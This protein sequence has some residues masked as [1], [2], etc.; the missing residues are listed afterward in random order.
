MKPTNTIGS[1]PQ[2]R[3][4]TDEQQMIVASGA[5]TLKVVAGAGCGKSSTLYAYATARRGVRGLYMAFS[6]ALEIEAKP[7]LLSLGVNTI[8]KT[9]HSLAWPMF[10]SK[11]KAAGKLATG[12]SGAVTTHALGL[13]NRGVG[14]AVNATLVNYMSSV[15]MEISD[16]HLPDADEFPAVK[17]YPGHVVECARK[18]WAKMTNIADPTKCTHDVYLK[19]W[20]MTKPILDYPFIMLDECQDS[21]PLIVDLVN[22]QTHATRVYVGDPHQAI[23]A[24][25]GAIDLMGTLNSEE[26]LR[27]TNSWRFGANIG[28]LASTFLKHW[29]NEATP[30]RGAGQPGKMTATDTRAYLT[31][32]VARLIENAVILQEE[33]GRKLY[34]VGPEGL[35]GYRTQPIMEAYEMFAGT[36]NASARTDPTLRLMESWEDFAE[37]AEAGN[38]GEL[39]PVFKLIDKHRNEIPGMLR[40]LDQKQVKAATL[41]EAQKAGATA[42]LTTAHR[43][44]GLEFPV[45]I[46]DRDFPSLKDRKTEKWLNPSDVAADELNLMYVA[47]TRAMKGVKLPTELEEWFRTRPETARLMPPAPPSKEGESSKVTTFRRPEQAER[48]TAY[49]PAA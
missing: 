26:T 17:A 47:L 46:I 7:K 27:L 13:K 42:A 15:D 41:E 36:G 21:N 12:L 24:F 20:C 32:T 10:G 19:Q 45:V 43:S 40:R 9:Q 5:K 14:S 11:L 22:R 1:L 33:K 16:R 28:T 29:K 18:F 34:W 6:K 48:D 31:R 35:A 2:F 3:N 37:Y 4:L 25:R 39:G 38:A 30:I 23:F 44:K 8:A 49:R